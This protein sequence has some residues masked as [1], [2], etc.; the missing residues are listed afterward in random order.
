MAFA[1]EDGHPWHALL[2][3]K[4]FEAHDM[5]S[6][7][8]PQ[9]PGAYPGPFASSMPR[10]RAFAGQEPPQLTAPMQHWPKTV[11]PGQ[12]PGVRGQD[13][14]GPRTGLRE[15]NRRVGRRRGQRSQPLALFHRVHGQ[16][17]KD[18][19]RPVRE[20]AQVVRT[21]YG[22]VRVTVR[23][24]DVERLV[25]TVLERAVAARWYLRALSWRPTGH[26]ATGGLAP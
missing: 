11:G 8:A 12:L 1:T 17:G 21:T 10:R 4:A 16:R 23:A 15:R 9:G 26:S 20:S 3:E 6:V 24:H 18:L 14:D 25:A 22:P 13:R 7:H 2:E 19:G 5:L